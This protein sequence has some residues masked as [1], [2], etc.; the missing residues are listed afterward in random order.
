MRILIV[1]RLQVRVHVE[2]AKY[3]VMRG[4]FKKDS[5]LFNSGLRKMDIRVPDT[6]ALDH[7]LVVIIRRMPNHKLAIKLEGSTRNVQGLLLIRC[8]LKGC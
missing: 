3:Q 7:Q 5:A 8:A 2:I 1:T 6:C 4:M